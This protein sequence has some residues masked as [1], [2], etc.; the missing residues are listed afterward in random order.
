[1]VWTKEQ[2]ELADDH[3][4]LTFIKAIPGEIEGTDLKGWRL[5]QVA[6]SDLVE[7]LATEPIVADVHKGTY[8]ECWGQPWT[9]TNNK[10]AVLEQ[11][12][13]CD[14]APAWMN[15]D[16]IDVPF[17]EAPSSGLRAA[18]LDA[19]TGGPQDPP[20]EWQRIDGRDLDQAEPREIADPATVSNVERDV[21]SIEFDVDA[22][23][24]GKPVVV[25]ESFYPNWNVEG[26][27]GP[28]RVSPNVMVVVPTAEHVKLTY[29][30]T[31]ADWLDTSSRDRS[32]ARRL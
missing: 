2:R 32:A 17:V 12:W 23:D 14:M 26:A 30:M 7:G 4:D 29:G 15:P 27:K 8:S 6:D 13:E 24:V 11:G 19:L 21:D 25:K 31:P 18:G 3:A 1:M 5:Y 16:L 20:Q 28:Y 9:D 22:D 10:E